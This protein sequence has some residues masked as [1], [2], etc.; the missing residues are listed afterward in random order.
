MHAAYLLFNGE[1]IEPML[2]KGLRLRMR[3]GLLPWLFEKFILRLRLK[4][5]I[6][7]RYRAFQSLSTNMV[8][9]CSDGLFFHCIVHRQKFWSLG[10]QQLI[11]PVLLFNF[12]G[13]GNSQSCIDPPRGMMF[14]KEAF[15]NLFEFSFFQK[16]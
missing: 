9:F 14:S 1:L 11:K 6:P 3:Y 16:V 5:V 12:N 7:K 13:V 15:E 2:E 10:T 4:L 8:L